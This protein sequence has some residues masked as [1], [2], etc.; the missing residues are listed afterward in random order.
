M[1]TQTRPLGKYLFQAFIMFLT[2]AT[3]MG[4]IMLPVLL[5]E[6]THIA[7]LYPLVLPLGWFAIGTVTGLYFRRT[8]S[9]VEACSNEGI[10]FTLMT[11]CG[12]LSFICLYKDKKDRSFFCTKQT[13]ASP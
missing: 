12:L 8:R 11:I 9:Y 1:Q 2:T 7:D 5:Q 3:I 6:S 4:M 10:I 13:T